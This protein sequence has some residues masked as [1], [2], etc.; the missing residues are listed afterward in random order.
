MYE[1]KKGHTVI[2]QI[3][4][5]ESYILCVGMATQ[6]APVNSPSGQLA[7]GHLALVSTRASMQWWHTHVYYVCEWMNAWLFTSS[8]ASAAS[9]KWGGT[10]SEGAKR[11]S[12]SRGRGGRGAGPPPTVGTFWIFAIENRHFNALCSRNQAKQQDGSAFHVF[13]NGWS[14]KWGGGGTNDMMSP[15]PPTF[16][17]GGDLSPLSPT[18]WRPC[19]S[20]MVY[21]WFVCARLFVALKIPNSYLQA[22]SKY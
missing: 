1:S 5:T 12:W 7:L 13:S 6:W 10:L 19:T 2:F 14:K 15:P 16:K 3:H 4:E 11:P 17:S 21:M 9:E 20:S 22:T 8:R 18:C